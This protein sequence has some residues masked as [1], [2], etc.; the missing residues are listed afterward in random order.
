MGLDQYAWAQRPEYA[1]LD[2]ITERELTDE[3]FALVDSNKVTLR[4][5]RKHADL[6]AWMTELYHR[7]GGTEEF[8]CITMPITRDDLM[9]LLHHIEANNGYA[10]R[11]NG[12]FWGETR[13]EDI[14]SDK[15]FIRLALNALDEG[16][17]VFYS[18]W[19]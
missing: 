11:G 1:H 15:E 4:E 12:F 2:L 10:E 6:N 19:Y 8:N 14:E 9:S 17:E 13:P 18:C 3:E 7:K 16:Y 5:W